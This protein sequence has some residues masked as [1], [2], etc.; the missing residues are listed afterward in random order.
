MNKIYKI[1]IVIT[2][3]AATASVAWAGFNYNSAGNHFLVDSVLKIGGDY[4]LVGDDLSGYCDN[5]EYNSQTLCEL[6]NSTWNEVITKSYC[7][8]SSFSDQS[9]CEGN[10]YVWN[11]GGESDQFFAI[12]NNMLFLKPNSKFTSGVRKISKDEFSTNAITV[13]SDVNNFEIST[14]GELGT[15]FLKADKIKMYNNFRTNKGLTIDSTRPWEAIADHSLYVDEI[16]ASEIKAF[17]S[18]KI[19]IPAGQSLT[20]A[21]G[22]AATADS[23]VMGGSGFCKKIDMVAVDQIMKLNYNK[24]K[25]FGSDQVNTTAC[26]VAGGIAWGLVYPNR[27]AGKVCCPKDHYIFDIH[28]GYA[29]IC[30]RAR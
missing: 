13:N 1:C 28:V 6:A 2:V 18:D 30:C 11:A 4:V 20:I 15:L 23:I 16:V 22:P 29:L 26:P 3:F 14:P 8:N 5:S 21:T 19:I 12:S 7:E 17:G 25:A 24:S 9:S 27:F 10:G